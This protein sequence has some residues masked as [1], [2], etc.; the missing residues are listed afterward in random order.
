MH[1]IKML[2]KGHLQ[3]RKSKTILDPSLRAHLTFARQ[4]IGWYLDNVEKTAAYMIAMGVSRQG[5][6]QP[7]VPLAS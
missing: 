6:V 7:C 1:L 3:E 4:V 5:L 2:F